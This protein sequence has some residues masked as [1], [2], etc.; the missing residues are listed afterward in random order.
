[1]NNCPFCSED[2]KKRL[3]EQG[4]YSYV[5]LSNPR[6]VPGHLLVI[7]SR[8]I[9]KLSELNN[10]EIKEVF[11]FLAKYQN[12]IL[13]KLGKGSEIRQNTRPYIKNTKT[14]INHL[15]FNLYPRNK[16]DRIETDIDAIRRSLYQD[17]TI[18][19][20]KK[21]LKLLKK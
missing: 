19:E 20:H 6:F 18:T 15:H 17:L 7:L 16:N 2:I 1:M 10:Q 14:H 9:Q 11:N 21:M 4:D 3:I 12:K 8:H 5:V 13:D